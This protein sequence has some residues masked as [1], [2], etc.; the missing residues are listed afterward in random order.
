M[1]TR[2]DAAGFESAALLL[3]P[4]WGQ[5]RVEESYA[6][7]GGGWTCSQELLTPTPPCN[8]SSSTAALKLPTLLGHFRRRVPASHFTELIPTS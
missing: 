8:L 6:G 4:Y 1:R 3:T 5:R 7:G 2:P